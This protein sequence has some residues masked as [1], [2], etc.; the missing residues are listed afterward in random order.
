MHLFRF[1]LSLNPN[2]S[3]TFTD[4]IFYKLFSANLCFLRLT[5]ALISTM[6]SS[7]T[8]LR[9]LTF[10]F[11]KKL[12]DAPVFEFLLFMQPE[13]SPHEPP[14][15][16]SIKPNDWPHL[17][18]TD[19]IIPPSLEGLEGIHF[20]PFDLKGSSDTMKRLLTT[21][22]TSQTFNQMVEG[23]AQFVLEDYFHIPKE[24]GIGA[25]LVKKV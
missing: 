9:E 1:T 12:T 17:R 24:K 6:V 20:T 14:T 5:F 8:S 10:D 7:K 4:S 11:N 21:G 19:P 2:Y 25:E 22:L 23:R 16:W 15:D 3:Q 13:A 18:W